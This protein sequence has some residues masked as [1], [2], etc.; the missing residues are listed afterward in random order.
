MSDH[1][2]GAEGVMDLIALQ[3]WSAG[4]LVVLITMCAVVFTVALT[5][6][7]E[8]KPEGDQDADEA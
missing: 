3:S 2:E 5:I 4:L 6:E 8:L 1:H 7:P